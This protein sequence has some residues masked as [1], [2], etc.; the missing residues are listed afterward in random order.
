MGGSDARHPPTT[1]PPKL[2]LDFFGLKVK[3]KFRGGGGGGLMPDT[4]PPPPLNYNLTLSQ[5]KVK[6]KFRGGG[7]GGSD[8]QTP[9]PHHP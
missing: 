7:G 3:L 9:P 5:K 6:L 1:P 2:Q 8:C 4:P